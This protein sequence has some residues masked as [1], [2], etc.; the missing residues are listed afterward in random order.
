MSHWDPK[1]LLSSVCLAK[2]IDMLQNIYQAFFTKGKAILFFPAYSGQAL[3]QT[4]TQLCDLC[5]S[6]LPPALGKY[7]KHWSELSTTFLFKLLLLALINKRFTG[8]EEAVA[9][10]LPS[11]LMPLVG[12]ENP[13]FKSLFQGSFCIPGCHKPT[14]WVWRA[15]ETF[16]ISI[17]TTRL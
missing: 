8:P 13:V 14:E 16:A 6:H 15:A 2:A 1:A 11:K 3:Q 17:L 9:R 7:P 4:L 5:H 10:K 12:K